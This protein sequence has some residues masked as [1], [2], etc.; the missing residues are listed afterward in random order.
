MMSFRFPPPWDGRDLVPV[1]IADRPGVRG[2]NQLHGN[3]LI[4][5]DVHQFPEL[6]EQVVAVWPK[7]EHGSSM[8]PT[9]D[10][11]GQ[12]DIEPLAHGLEPAGR[13]PVE[14]LGVL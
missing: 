1:R 6:A 12:V 5:Q 3:R 7:P 10:G 2:G 4:P 9:Q 14:D 13:L 11:Y 8:L